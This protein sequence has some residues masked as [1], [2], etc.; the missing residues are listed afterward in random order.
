[1][2]AQ[3]ADP[4]STLAFYRSALATRRGFAGTA[5][6]EVELLD[7]EPD[8]VAFRRGDIICHL[9]CGLT[10]VDVPDG[11]VLLCSGPTPGAPDTATWLQSSS[12][13]L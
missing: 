6:D 2:E 11:E 5:G 9:N 10:P 12:A 13:A 3:A 7:S 8:V 4:D 1:V